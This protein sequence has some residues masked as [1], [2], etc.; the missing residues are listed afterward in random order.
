MVDGADKATLS[1]RAVGGVVALG[2][3]EGAMRVLAFAGDIA[4]YRLLLPEVFGLVVPVAFLA[5]II[6]HFSDLG[7]AASLI[8]SPDEPRERDLRTV[9][10]VQAM[11]VTAAAIFIFF[12]G[13]L[14]LDA[15]DEGSPDPWLIRAFGL[16]ILLSVF[17]AVPAAMLE[18]HLQF[19]RLATADVSGTVWFYAAGLALA[20][21]GAGP[22]A[23]VAAHVGGSVV[24]TLLLLFLYPWRPSLK[25]DR[26]RLLQNIDFGAKFQGQRLLL[27]LKD[28]LIPILGPAAFGRSATGFL[29]WADKIAQQPLL[30]TQLVA[31]VS[32]PAL[33]RAQGEMETVRAGAML[34]LKWNCLLT[35]PFFALIF[36]FAEE[37]AGLI[38]GD[39]WTP[40]VPALYVLTVNAMLVPINGLLYPVLN[41]IGHSGRLLVVS[42]VWTAVAWGLAGILLL[43]G[44]DYR[45][46]AVGLVGS[47]IFAFAYLLFDIKRI[48]GINVLRPVAYPAAAAALSG[49]IGFLFLRPVAAN[50]PMLLLLGAVLLAGY[51]AAIYALDGKSLRNEGLSALRL[52][53]RDRRGRG[54][55]TSL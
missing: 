28:S 35:F 24:P 25:I 16:S 48:V 49:L 46:V 17:R 53:R 42:A 15:L 6:K 40:A 27:M 30:L 19:G 32:L 39:T 54:A 10:T 47:Q 52:R 41:A 34:A 21:A 31:R 4:L 7:L 29:S 51:S 3:R 5:G 18:R 43:I 2:A 36:A 12:A 20:A 45:A 9:F 33:S 14:I 26:S 1:R 44:M 13:P 11:L 50:I 8:Q 55:V 23:L 22:W 38:Y 37:I